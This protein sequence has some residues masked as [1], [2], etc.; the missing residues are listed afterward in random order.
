MKRIMIR[1][2]DICPDMNYERF[3]K[4]RDMLIELEIKPLIGVIPH[5]KD[6]KLR[7]FREESINKEDEDI[8]SEIRSLQNEQG[9]EIALHGYEHVYKTRNG[10]ILQMALKSEF[11]GIPYDEQVRAICEGKKRLE[12]LGL[13]CNAFMAPSHSFDCNTLKALA[14]AEISIITDGIGLFPYEMEG[15]LMMPAPCPIYRNL[16]FGIYTVFLHTN[17]MTDKDIEKIK[18]FILRE[19]KYIISFSEGIDL[20][21]RF[22]NKRWINMINFIT[23]SFMNIG[24][25]FIG[26]ISRLRRIGR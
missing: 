3:A 19:R 7:Q 11:A 16:P 20:C 9:W 25:P 26:A 24:L 12:S 21:T 1:L 23:N 4:V 10:G 22:R 6:N 5:N 18:R 8:W 14:Q 13:R 15:C 2:D 17:T